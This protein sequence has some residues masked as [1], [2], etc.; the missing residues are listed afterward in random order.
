MVTNDMNTLK[1]T[2]R[3]GYVIVQL[4]RGK[5]NAIN[6]ALVEEVRSLFRTLENDPAVGGVVLTGSS[7]IFSA[8]LD[9]IELMTYDESGI[10]SFLTS[11]GMMHV[12]LSRFSKPLI[13]AITGFSPAGGTVIAITADYR[14]MVDDPKYTLGL[15]EMAVNVQITRNLTEAY[16]FWL[17]RSLANRF[18]LEG[19]LLNPQE[20][21]THHLV[22]EICPQDEVLPRAE[23]KMQHYLKADPDIFSYTKKALRQPWFDAQSME[24]QADLEQALKIWWKPEVRTK[25]EALIASF[26]NKKK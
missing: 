25:M 22:D 17:G 7:K 8:G 11:F 16:A 23:Q 3:E 4:D 6:A 2:P 9:L 19:K 10:R 20:A 13:C 12:E 1:V 15:N 26:S 24:G 21:V 5:V 14:V 18:V